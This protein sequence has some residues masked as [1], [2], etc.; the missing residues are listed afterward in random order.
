MKKKLLSDIPALIGMLITL[1][2]AF[3][4]DYLMRALNYRVAQTFSTS[5]LIPLMY[6]LSNLIL[7]A[8]LL[9]LFWYVNFRAA[10][11]RFVSITF[12]VAG[13]LLLIFWPAT[14]TLMIMIPAFRPPTFPGLSYVWGRTCTAD[15]LAAI[16]VIGLLGLL[17]RHE[18]PLRQ[19][20]WQ[21]VY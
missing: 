6:P 16:A 21:P 20:G 13:L 5:P 12:L 3:G 10:R 4:L 15:A 17:P 18:T 2:V 1:A 19:S 7:A 11:S 9:L 8:C 14:M